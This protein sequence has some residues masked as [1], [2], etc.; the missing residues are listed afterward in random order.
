MGQLSQLK[1]GVVIAA[2]LI[3]SVP[4]AAEAKKDHVLHS[5]MGGYDDGANPM[6]ELIADAQGN[7]YGTTA[8]GGSEDDCYPAGGY[9]C[10]TVF[11]LAP[12]GT[13]K[14]L[15]VFSGNADGAAPHSGLVLDAAGNL[16]GTTFLGGAGNG[17]IFKISP[18]GKESTL[19]TFQ[20]GDDGGVLNAGLIIDGAGNLY[21][22]TVDGGA[23]GKGTVFELTPRGKLKTLYSFMG[24]SD[25]AAPVARLARDAGGN[26][27]G[28]TSAGG[29]VNC[30]G[31]GVAQ[32]S[33]SRRRDRKPSCMPSRAAT[34][35]VRN[36]S[37]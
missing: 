37:A 23:G 8:N 24:G 2:M 29:G 36:L 34:M 12:D 26:L 19:Y 14:V 25:G 5:F 15:Y 11:K 10:G 6:A 35:M 27:Y 21:G 31:S 7:F 1:A 9:G 30:N 20:G 16:Y 33:N 4:N 13:E 32:F 28:P 22:T 18:T 3:A 17:V